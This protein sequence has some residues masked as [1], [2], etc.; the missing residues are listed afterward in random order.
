MLLKVFNYVVNIFIEDRKDGQ[1]VQY[2]ARGNPRP[3][4][5]A[6]VI[7]WVRHAWKSIDEDLILKDIRYAVC[8]AL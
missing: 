4:E 3:P 1:N 7:E 8:E 2:R 6:V 5:K